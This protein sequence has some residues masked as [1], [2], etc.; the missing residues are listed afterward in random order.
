MEVQWEHLNPE[1]VLEPTLWQ[2]PLHR[3]LAAFEAKSSAVM[4]RA[5]LLSFDAAGGGFASARSRTTPHALAALG[6]AISW[7]QSMQCRT[8]VVLILLKDCAAYSTGS[9]L[10]R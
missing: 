5:S 1:G 4:S 10:T 9:T 2:T 8:H 6:C 7:L 3:N